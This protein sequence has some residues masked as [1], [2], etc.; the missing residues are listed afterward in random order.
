MLEKYCHEVYEAFKTKHFNGRSRL[1]LDV[2][3]VFAVLQFGQGKGTK[4]DVTLENKT[5]A[6]ALTPPARQE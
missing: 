4:T 3:S 6:Q 1:F 5:P 2:P